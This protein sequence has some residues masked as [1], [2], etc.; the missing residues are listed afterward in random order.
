MYVLN[1][2]WAQAEPKPTMGSTV[3]T[4][5]WTHTETELLLYLLRLIKE[6]NSHNKDKYRL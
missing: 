1:I 6:K 2:R 3:R 5:H 4:N